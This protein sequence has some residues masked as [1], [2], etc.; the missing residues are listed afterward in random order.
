MSAGQHSFKAPQISWDWLPARC[1]GVEFRPC[2]SL[3]LMFSGEQSFWT[4]ARQPFFAASSRAASPLNKSWMS[5]SPSL[6]MSSGMLPSRFFLVG[7]A[8]CYTNTLLWESK[9]ENIGSWS[10]ERHL[11]EPHL[12]QQFADFIFAFGCSLMKGCELP[13]ICHIH[14]SSM[15][16]QQFSYLIVTVGARIVKRNKTAAEGAAHE[17][18]SIQS[19]HFNL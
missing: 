17:L 5:V 14:W 16:D 1:N 2:V 18:R 4:R 12:Q 13:Q 11:T 19:P 7:S 6:T 15:S 9:A 10:Q 8:P 3:Q